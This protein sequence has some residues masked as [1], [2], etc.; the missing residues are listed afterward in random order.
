MV[1]SY[2]RLVLVPYTEAAAYETLARKGIAQT[3]SAV[4]A[5]PWPPVLSP[6]FL[7][8]RAKRTLT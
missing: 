5:A 2:L 3:L 1:D 8:L 7:L 4:V 6:T